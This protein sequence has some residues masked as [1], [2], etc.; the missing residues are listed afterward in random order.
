[1]RPAL[2]SVEVKQL[3]H[4]LADFLVVCKDRSILWNKSLLAA[5]SPFLG[6]LMCEADSVL[7]LK[8][9]TTALVKKCF[10]LLC[11]LKSLAQID[12]N[13]VIKICRIL[14]IGTGMN[15]ADSAPIKMEIECESPPMDD[16]KVN[17][18]EMEV[19][20]EL[21]ELDSFDQDSAFDYVQDDVMAAMKRRPRNRKRRETH[22][23]SFSD[24]SN[25]P[26]VPKVWIKDH[27]PDRYMDGVKTEEYY[28]ST[29]SLAA[30]PPY[31]CLMCHYMTPSKRNLK[32]H[33]Q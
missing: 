7:I 13:D 31:T 23:K 4:T 21:E 8:D 26:S 10:S 28:M 17:L 5:W 32:L 19:Y 3:A 27:S 9:F 6:G 1:M 33:F 2:S 15:G 11:C 16:A 24:P 29:E 22:T 18:Q 12:D 25:R 20:N 30:G 14:M